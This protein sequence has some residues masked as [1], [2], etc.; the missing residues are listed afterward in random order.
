MVRAHDGLPIASRRIRAGVIDRTGRRLTPLRVRVGR[1]N[2]V[3]VRAVRRVMADLSLRARVQGVRVRTDVPEQPFGD[4]AL[5][6]AAN[7]ARAAIGTGESGIG[8]AA[9]RWGSR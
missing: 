7:R 2:P 5:T 3:K 6:G 1:D 4:A 8:F 9:G